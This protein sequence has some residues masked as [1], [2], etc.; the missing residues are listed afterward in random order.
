MEN[1]PHS[2]I[3][4]KKEMSFAPFFPKL[5]ADI[6]GNHSL[7][8]AGRAAGDLS[9]GAHDSNGEHIADPGEYQRAQISACGFG[10][11]PGTEL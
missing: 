7:P 8:K 10:N 11:C 2:V 3:V 6:D 5:I 9:A 1:Q 4:V